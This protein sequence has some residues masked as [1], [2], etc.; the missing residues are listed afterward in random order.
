MAELRMLPH[1]LPLDVAARLAGRVAAARQLV[2]QLDSTL[3][4]P[5]PPVE[6]LPAYLYDEMRDGSR[7]ELLAR[8]GLRP[9]TDAK[10]WSYTVQIT[11][12]TLLQFDDQLILGILAHEFLHVVADTLAAYKF[13]Q[14][15]SGRAYTQRLEPG[16]NHSYERYLEVDRAAGADP[17][18][19]LTPDLRLLC[20]RV[21]SGDDPAVHAAVDRIDREWVARGLPIERSSPGTPVGVTIVLDSNI[22]NHL[23][24]LH[25]D[26][27]IAPPRDAE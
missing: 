18:I 16:Y 9:Y 19:W 21:E 7:M 11:A 23:S 15:G 17:H 14:N 27:G 12:P 24:K 4:V 26:E 10:T 5:Y 3:P 20:A 25:R 2:R 1:A 22:I 8:V 13:L 6:I